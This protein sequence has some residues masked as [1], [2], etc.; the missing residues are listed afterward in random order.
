MLVEGY[1]VFVV[2]VG[3]F[4]VVVVIVVDH[5]ASGTAIVGDI[6]LR[7]D[8]TTRTAS[9]AAPATVQGEVAAMIFAPV[10]F[11]TQERGGLF[12]AALGRF[13]PH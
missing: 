2:Q 11:R 12:A 4:V 6:A 1:G 9:D 10:T 3:L 8:E 13:T 5:D 7:S